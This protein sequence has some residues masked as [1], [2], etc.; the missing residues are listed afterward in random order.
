M[1]KKR[2]I[3][4]KKYS[5]LPYLVFV[6][7]L[8]S[9]RAFCNTIV[10][11]DT[12]LFSTANSEIFIG[13][14][15]YI[16]EDKSNTLTISDV[17]KSNAFILHNGEVP[18]MGI[19]ASSFW[20][21]FSIKNTSD[22]ENLL[23]EVANPLLD[24][25]EF[26]TLFQNNEF[27]VKKMGEYEK[28][29]TRKYAHPSYLFDLN[30]PKGST[31]DYY[32]KFKS[33]EDMSLPIK[34]GSQLTI[35]DS[36]RAKD[37]LFGLYAGI[38]VV[39]FLYNTFIYSTTKD[40]SYLFYII[41]ILSVTLTQASFQGYTFQFLFFDSPWLAQ[42]SV[43]LFSSFVGISAGEFV[44]V[45]LDTKTNFPKLSKALYLF[46]LS[47]IV[48]II[49]SVF[50]INSMPL[51]NV[52]ALMI[53]LFILFMAIIL[54]RKGNRSAG[55]FLVAWT[56]FLI[57][58]IVFALKNSGIIPYNNFTIYTMP[59]GSAIEAILLSFA[60]ADRI[61]I[62]KKEKEES[63][64]TALE[65]LKENEKLITEQNI[66]LERNVEQR[67]IELKNTLTNLKDAQ[68]QLVNAEKMAS[69]G[70]LTAG[71]AHEIN[72]PINFVSANVKPLK[73]D[74]AD[75]LE[76]LSKYELIA[77]KEIPGDKLNEIE[78]F[79][80]EID[81]DYLK[82]EMSDLLSG[83]EDGAKRTADIVSGLKNFSR[84]DESDIKEAN[85]NEGIES[86]LILLKSAVP[87]NTEV[88]TNLGNIPVIECLP[89]KLNQVFMNLFSN[90]FY[91]ISR[92]ENKIGN[93][94]MI[95][96]YT[97]G[98]QV[99]VCIEDTG[100]G[101]TKEVKDKM[102]DP[103][104]TT[105]DVGEGTGLGMSIVFKIMESH[106]AIMEVESEYGVGTKIL[107]ILNKKVTL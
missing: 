20:L 67:T 56:T 85:I 74:I 99:F 88:I 91:A 107:L 87:E 94:L 101:M 70:Q 32:F 98:A 14:S 69:L 93:K 25:I 59:A 48:C 30:I 34:L 100:I 26:Y 72:N 75:V 6:C 52:T 7:V 11:Q 24:E 95:S 96:T 27:S 79:K 40:K 49:L 61:N 55:F 62:L 53:S 65:A 81:I 63:Q 35:M 84:L 28:F 89:G 16:F 43:I 80:K 3:V 82:K 78:E 97:S 46:Y 71:I 4:L 90:A 60:L 12:I 31:C 23:I 13:K 77:S 8:L 103:F 102:F 15:V 44:R 73:M 1:D 19:S 33:N 86:T 58:V 64:A 42:K 50:E 45:F 106:G 104:F 68:T 92:K 47:Y 5:I 29:D 39:M 10:L 21:K 54:V 76:L 17:A 57:G 2:S 66:V 83:I 9:Q 41:Y 51:L 105:K 22:Q 18:N 36:I 38:M 37:L